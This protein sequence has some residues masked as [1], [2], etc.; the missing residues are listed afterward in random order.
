MH[1]SRR[2]SIR[3]EDIQRFFVH[4]KIILVE[5]ASTI[6]LLVL[7]YEGLKHEMKW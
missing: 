6:G 3:F 2:S 4:T 1:I 7:L 5:I